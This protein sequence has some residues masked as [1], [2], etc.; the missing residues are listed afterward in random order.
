MAEPTSPASP[1][2]RPGGR[3]APDQSPAEH[4]APD[5]EGRKTD[6]HG[7][8]PPDSLPNPMPGLDPQQTPGIDRLAGTPLADAV[9]IRAGQ[10]G[11]RIF[12]RRSYEQA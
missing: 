12:S 4:P 5:P 6:K 11:K 3:P 7:H 1:G 10:N 2:P 9:R 8:W